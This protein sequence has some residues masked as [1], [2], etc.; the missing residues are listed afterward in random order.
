VPQSHGF[1]AF[2]P[3]P[4]PTF[5]VEGRGRRRPP[6]FF[7]DPRCGSAA[8]SGL[9]GSCRGVTGALRESEARL[10]RRKERAKGAVHDRQRAIA[11]CSPAGGWPA[12]RGETPPWPD[13]SAVFAAGGYDRGS[14]LFEGTDGGIAANGEAGRRRVVADGAFRLQGKGTGLRAAPHLGWTQRRTRRGAP[15]GA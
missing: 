15:Q 10:R 2:P 11:G 7:S 9:A 3:D 5:G 4:P 13:G 12:R 8:R 14:N 6:P 1:R